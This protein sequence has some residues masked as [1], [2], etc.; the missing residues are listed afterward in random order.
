[1]L[2]RKE[3]PVRRDRPL[4]L[5]FVVLI[6]SLTAPENV[7]IVTDIAKAPMRPGEARIVIGLSSGVVSEERRS[8]R[9]KSPRDLRW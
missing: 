2:F 5:T 1:M 7:A 4:F 6:P 8:E 9:K 3:R